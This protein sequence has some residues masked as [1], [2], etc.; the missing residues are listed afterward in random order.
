MKPPQFLKF[1][2]IKQKLLLSYLTIVLLIVLIIGLMTVTVLQNVLR[3]EMIEIKQES[4]AQMKDKVQL[5]TDHILAV[6]NIYYINSDLSRILP[7]ETVPGS[8]E[9]Y[10]EEA[11]FDELFYQYDFAF[12]WLDY[13]TSIIGFNG[14]TFH[15]FTPEQDPALLSRLQ[16]ENWYKELPSND[17]RVIWLSDIPAIQEI[18]DN[19]ESGLYAVRQLHSMFTGKAI[20][21][22]IIG[23]DV[24][25]FDKRLYRGSVQQGEFVYIINRDNELVSASDRSDPGEEESVI[26]KGVGD[27]PSKGASRINLK[28]MVYQ[29]V[30]DSTAM[31][32]WKIISLEK[33]E[34][35]FAIIYLSR[36]FIWIIL[37]L[38][39]MAATLLALYMAALFSRPIQQLAEEMQ[40]VE[41]GDLSIHS[42]VETSDEIGNLAHRFNR[43]LEKTR[44]LVKNIMLI[45]DMKQKAELEAL[46]S[47]INPHFIYNSLGTIRFM[48]RLESKEAVDRAMISLT[49]MLR[50]TLSGDNSL[51]MLGQELEMTRNYLTI[52]EKQLQDPLTV[53]FTIAGETENYYIPKL[54][55]QPLVENAIFHGI[56][57]LKTAGKIR[58]ESRQEAD[59][60]VLD[61]IDNGTGFPYKSIEKLR[62]NPAVERK[63]STGNGIGLLNIHDRLLLRFGTGYGLFLIDPVEKGCH[64]QIRMPILTSDQYERRAPD[65]SVS[66]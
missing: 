3:K 56:K 4:L 64:I 44:E 28:G 5:I 36:R 46:Q 31:E 65:E 8:Y 38:C 45:T 60:L 54:I 27:G 33:E 13:N 16:K 58:I 47:Q 18:S 61:I 26:L 35:L 14:K 41:A 30:W 19:S 21:L 12:D 29:A 66:G 10:K 6:S 24:S 51:V 48:L 32:E 55:I 52:A 2:T 23:V 42:S 43:M 53:D 40:K 17:G 7:Q 9:W 25:S 1:K 39:L 59:K 22:L 49:K 62:G 34:S 63:D 50:Y 20:G 57:V 15:S 37:M 11:L